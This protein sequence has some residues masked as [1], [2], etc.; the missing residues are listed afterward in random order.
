MLYLSIL[1][2]SRLT[3]GTVSTSPSEEAASWNSLKRQA[4]THPVVDLERPTWQLTMT[5]QL[6]ADPW[7]VLQTLSKSASVGAAELQTGILMWT[8]PG[9]FSLR[10]SMTWERVVSSLTST[11]HS[12][13]L[14]ST[15]L[16]LLSFPLARPSIT[17]R[18]SSS[19]FLT[20]SRVTSPSSA[21]SPILLGGRAQMGLPFT[22]T[23]DSWRMLSQMILLVLG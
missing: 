7:R 15:Y 3:P 20:L 12:F 4:A 5:G 21:Y 22:Y 13:L 18:N 6:T 1:R 8:S 2:R 19:S 9:N 16:S 14:T 11:S 17:L 10:P 23:I